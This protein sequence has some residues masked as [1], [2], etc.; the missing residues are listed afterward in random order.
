MTP[1]TLLAVLQFADGLFPSG[2]FAHS[3]GL[4]TYVQAGAVRDGRDLEAF[5]VAH[6]EGG[7]G[8]ADAVAAAI[9]ARVA[10]GADLQ[11]CTAV[12]DQLD[13]Q[14]VLAR[15]RPRLVTLA[16]AA[17]RADI[18]D[19][20]SFTPGLDIAGIRHAGLESRLFRS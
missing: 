19:M 16:A 2:G 15:V 13:A 9:A 1:D 4:E 8:P 17:A 14:R 6:L 3:F 10:A 12:D 20:W 11:G 7:L 18:D 5:V